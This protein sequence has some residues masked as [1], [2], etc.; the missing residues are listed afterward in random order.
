MNK[1]FLSGVV[2]DAPEYRIEKNETAH[3]TFNL[4]VRHQRQAGDV[5]RELYRINAWNRKAEWGAKHLKK[6]QVVCFEGCLT[7]RQMKL[8]NMVIPCTEVTVEEFA[9][10]MNRERETAEGQEGCLACPY[11]AIHTNAL[12]TRRTQKGLPTGQE[13]EDEPEEP[14][15]EPEEEQEEET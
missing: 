14:E 13:H 4:V 11:A 8:G 15:E 2:S 5:K 10:N 1:V 12:S 3:L 6:G 7:Q 9:A